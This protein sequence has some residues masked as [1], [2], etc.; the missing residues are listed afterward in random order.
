M[1]TQILGHFDG[2]TPD[3]WLSGWV[4]DERSR[5]RKVELL[6]RLD[7]QPVAKVIADQFRKDLADGGL[8]NP[9]CAF[10]FKVPEVFWDGHAHSVEVLITPENLPLPNSP[11][12]FNLKRPSLWAEPSCSDNYIANAKLSYWPNG[13][14]LEPKE[15][16]VELAQGWFF[17]FKRGTS[18]GAQFA[19]DKPQGSALRDDEYGMRI[20]LEA[21]DSKGYRR[22]IAPLSLTPRSRPGNYV[23]SCGLKARI[24]SSGESVSIS[25][26]FL[27]VLEGEERNVV[28]LASVRKQIILNG[29]LRLTHVPVSIS[30]EFLEKV[31]ETSRLVLVFDLKGTGELLLFGPHLSDLYT[32]EQPN[33]TPGEFE[34][35]KIQEQ[36]PFLALS[37]IWSEGEL[38]SSALAS[39]AEPATYVASY[40]QPAQTAMPFIQIVVPVFNA[41][42]DTA[43]LIASIR[44]NTCRPYEVLLLDDGSDPHTKQYLRRIV[45]QDPRFILISND[46]NLGYTRN[47][48]KGLQT[49]IADYVVLLNSDTIVT[50]GW[51]E[52]LY[53]VIS[54]DPTTAAV[55]P[56]SNAASW[57][58]VPATKARDG[59]WAINELPAGVNLE[60]YASSIDTLSQRAFPEFPL[61]NGF[62]TLFR[63]S[64][65]EAVDYFDDKTFPQGYGEENDLCLRLVRAGFQLRVADHA[66][67]YHK[68]SK[69]FGAERRK[70]LSQKANI[71]LKNKFPEVHLP[72]LEERMAICE[73]IAL[74]RQRLLKTTNVEKLTPR[75]QPSVG[76]VIKIETQARQLK[77]RGA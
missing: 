47:V 74:L 57:Q 54:R 50:P 29:T 39:D 36:V 35:P 8:Q 2:V 66:Y 33:L 48:N 44:R 5:S 75:L 23:L 72:S 13:V 40:R 37:P 16:F 3:G 58:S 12:E 41:P 45:D 34:D 53:E 49:T 11:S 6:I 30:P 4:C 26:I 15:R 51:L 1:S 28:R 60:E 7:G 17:D 65:L 10:W 20:S 62:C 63:R 61:L 59:G 27:A 56:L 25:E 67:V 76:R 32:R 18:P 43:E 42:A 52:K 55:G 31:D 19:I 68:K 73:P 38:V 64:A 21:S 9:S 77:R 69:S 22:L 70:D 71:K 24:D 46:G 14:F